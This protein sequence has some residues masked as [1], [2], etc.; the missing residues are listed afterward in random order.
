MSQHP[1]GVQPLGNCLLRGGCNIRH[2]GLGSL[3][4]L[5]DELLLSV[6]AQV[7]ARSLVACAG[8]SKALHC[9]ATHEELW[10][11]MALQECEGRFRF[12]GT[13][14]RTYLAARAAR[15]PPPASPPLRAP[16]LYSDLLHK[17]H[18]LATRALDPAWLA[19]DTLPRAAGLSIAEFRARF[20]EPN[21]PVV[22]TGVVNQWPAC[23]RWTHKYLRKAY[24]GQ[25]AVVANY[26]MAF[27]DY[28]AY[29][30]GSCDDMPLY[31]FDSGFAEKAPRLVGDYL[32]PELFKEDLFQVL[33]DA[34][35]AHRWLI[36]GPQRSGST[37]HK[38][39]NATSAWNAVV[40]GAK[41]W[42]LFPPHV[43]PPGVHPSA[44][45]TEVA[46]P[47]SLVEW[48]AD[49]YADAQAGEARPVEGIVRAGELLFVPRGWWHLAINLEESVAVTHNYLGPVGLPAALA[50]ARAPAAERLVSGCADRGALADRLV[51]A[52]RQHRPEVLAGLQEQGQSK[53][54]GACLAELFR[55]GGNGNPKHRRVSAAC[56]RSGEPVI[57]TGAAVEA[58]AETGA[59]FRFNFTALC[60]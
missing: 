58:D 48:F 46:T 50:F 4:A 14:R 45:G 10:R 33:G 21:V 47:L 28:A 39:P 44:D 60:N 5:S 42:V 15:E 49:F 23:K 12:R 7:S 6:L 30:R 29:C 31:L 2:P 34:R 37:F 56:V 41:K 1:N 51:A 22:I 32:V 20:E 40:R 35:P 8:A 13:W 54:K 9:F 11:A 55:G 17:P 18:W 43:I 24:G 26:D 59:G 19:R 16:G 38:D 27:G 3:A 52:L 25:P 53:R 57:E 36:V